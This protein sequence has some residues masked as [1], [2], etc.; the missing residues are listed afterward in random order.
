MRH[1]FSVDNTTFFQRIQFCVGCHFTIVCVF[2]ML[3][4]ILY[5]SSFLFRFY[6]L[7]GWFGFVLDLGFVICIQYK[8]VHLEIW[9]SLHNTHI[10][11]QYIQ[12]QIQHQQQHAQ[13]NQINGTIQHTQRHT[14]CWMNDIS[15]SHRVHS[16]QIIVDMHM[17]ENDGGW[18]VIQLLLLLWAKITWLTGT[19]FMCTVDGI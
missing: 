14:Y 2:C 18:T 6:F 1:R 9:D 11:T 15:L 10:H 4:T 3:W 7:F 13:I 8:F 17:N 19:V 5:F 16:T 12:I